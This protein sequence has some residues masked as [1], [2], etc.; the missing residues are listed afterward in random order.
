MIENISL[1]YPWWFILFCAAAGA[2][3][4]YLLYGKET[5]FEESGKWIKPAMAAFRAFSVFTITLLLLSPIIKSVKE[6]QKEPIV[7][8][9]N[10]ISQSTL[11]GNSKDQNLS[12]KSAL[13]GLNNKI[14]SKFRVANLEFADQV[15]ADSTTK[16]AVGSSNLSQA[17]QY[18]YDNYADQNVGA[19]VMVSDGIYN[20]GGHPAYAPVQ[21]NAPLFTVALGDTSIR[22]DLVVKNVLS[23]RIAYLG[24]QFPIQV[25][26][27]ALS[28]QGSKSKLSL[29]RT[30]AKGKQLL[31][32][33]DINI[34]QQSFFTTADFVVDASQIG[35][36]KYTISVSPLSGEVST[37]NN[38]KDIY[39]EILDGR[40][41]VLI[42]GNSPHPDLA[43]FQQLISTHKN[44]KAQTAIMG[45]DKPNLADFDVI[46]AHNLPSDQHDW[47]AELAIIKNKKIP[48]IYV[49]GSQVNQ[50]RLNGVQDVV[51]IKGNSRSNE[52]TEVSIA[53]G[54]D[55]FTLSEDLKSKVIKF[56]PLVNLFGTY[57]AASAT[58]VLFQ[59]KIKKI[60]TR[61]PLLAF[62]EINGVKTG[63]LCGEGIWKWKIQEYASYQNNETSQELVNKMVQLVAAK[64]DKRKFKVNLPKQIFK[65]NENIVF[66]AQLFNDA[67]EMFNEPEVFMTV[68][69]EN[70]KEYKY[71]F[72]K[73]GNYY[74][75][76]IG[77][78]PSGNYTF[79]ANTSTKGQP[80]VFNGKF[81]VEA[82]QLEAYDLTARHDVLAALSKKF[83]GATYS[84]QQMDQ[85]AENILKNPE[86]KPTIFQTSHSKSIIHFKWLFFLILTLLSAEWFM[87]RYY[88]SY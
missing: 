78:M 55:L 56:P 24:D 14:S 51:K 21:F 34:T 28:C 58:Q 84:I 70:K 26:I 16:I 39:I 17:V 46:I 87:R 53:N 19:I 38:K 40:Q 80:Q 1:P 57:E 66:D 2:G 18:I 43:A 60:P 48:V 30:D 81:S 4:A 86:L 5:K 13:E 50:S 69:D 42:L 59:Q 11:L 54:F 27:S 23:N 47:S 35:V 63:V 49:A 82:L 8:I 31:A 85:L 76:D 77:Q 7:V 68:R 73:T 67:Y 72:S 62:N 25:D 3:Y 6:E 79:Q 88:G 36:I 52:E 71:T 65:D 10:D 33:K 83:N 32:Q 12:L 61:Y 75:L 45:A 29:E 37:A 9:A 41:N 22:K 44:Y 74:L 15:R 20:E 64:D